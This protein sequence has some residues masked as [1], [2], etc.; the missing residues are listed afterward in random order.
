MVA[1]THPECRAAGRSVGLS[2]MLLVALTISST[3]AQGQ[4]PCPPY[5]QPNAC[6]YPPAVYNNCDVP[7]WAQSP[8]WNAV[9]PI[10]PGSQLYPPCET[11]CPPAV[12]AGSLCLDAVRSG[13][14]LGGFEFLWMRAHFDQ[15]VALII[16]PPVGN[17]SVPFDYDRDL[18]PRA[19][20][21][22]ESCR[23]GGVR[24]TY[25]GLDSQADSVAV[26]AV[27]GATPV[28]VYVYGAGGNLSRNAQAQVGETLTS[29]HQ[30]NLQAWDI[31]AT[32]RIEWH[33]LRATL[34]VGVRIATMDQYLRG[35]VRDG[36][37]MLQ[38]SVS[39]DLQWE[40]AGPTM[41]LQASR[42]IAGSRLSIY[43]GLRGSLLMAEADQ[44]IYEMKGA[45]TTELEDAASQTELITALEMSIGLQ[46]SQALGAHADWFARVG[47]EA[48]AWFDA[49]GPVDS[50]STLALDGVSLALGLR[51]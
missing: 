35:D 50:H 39:N 27:A 37:G 33:S 28:Y 11:P 43:G 40:G 21:G 8:N 31:E 41:S 25:F 48:Q 47:Y 13:R 36:A 22:W 45:F 6:N 30:L 10:P 38:E 32:Q 49:G 46:W 34:G 24:A 5:Y 12:P 23:G 14:Y 42:C 15:N 1:R 51:Y 18:T 4:A 16:D 26:T 9:Q 19:W 2:G 3:L 29:Q 44:K 17:T 7:A 20:L